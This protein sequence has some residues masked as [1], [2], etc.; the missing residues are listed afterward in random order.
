MS[1]NYE[2]YLTNKQKNYPFKTPTYTEIM[3]IGSPLIYLFEAGSKEN[4]KKHVFYSTDSDNAISKIETIS[5]L[6]NESVWTEFKLNDK[7][8]YPTDKG[9]YICEL[10][11]GLNQICYWE[12]G[13]FYFRTK[14]TN[15]SYISDQV[16]AYRKL[17]KRFVI[18]Q[19]IEKELEK[20]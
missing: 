10:K 16:L 14:R 17:R 13:K 4:G 2:D 19:E 6:I 9:E 5:A 20:L 3:S 1:E 15:H 11:D 8:T 7:K 12:N 18:D